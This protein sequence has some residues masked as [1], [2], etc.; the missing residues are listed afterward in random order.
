V[1][2]AFSNL[3]CL[4]TPHVGEAI[5]RASDR[6]RMRTAVEIGQGAQI[7][8]YG[9]QL[10]L[11]CPAEAERCLIVDYVEEGAAKSEHELE[12]SGMVSAA[13]AG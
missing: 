9:H 10:G 1:A 6:Y 2:A 8:H 5:D 4:S 3:L 12:V 11:P 13:K 7:L